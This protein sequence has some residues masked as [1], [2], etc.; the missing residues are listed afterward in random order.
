MLV[1]LPRD[2]YRLFQVLRLH[3]VLDNS[4]G[5]QLD[6]CVVVAFCDVNVP[7]LMLVCI[8]E[9]LEAVFAAS[10][11]Y[12]L[13]QK[14]WKAALHSQ[15]VT[16][17]L[18]KLANF[19]EVFVRENATAQ[20]GF[21]QSEAT[22]AQLAEAAIADDHESVRETAV[23]AI[24]QSARLD[25]VQKIIERLDGG[26]AHA[27]AALVTLRDQLPEVDAMIPAD[28][29][30]E[31]R[32]N[33]RR[34]RWQRHRRSILLAAGRGAL[35]GAIAMGFGFWLFLNLDGLN[36]EADIFDLFSLFVSSILV[37][38]L[39]GA[40]MLGAGAFVYQAVKSILDEGN[41]PAWIAASIVAGLLN[42]LLFMFVSFINPVGRIL[43][44]A[45]IS[46]FVMGSALCL[47]VLAPPLSNRYARFAATAAV[48]LAFYL[49]LRLLEMPFGINNVVLLLLAA[50]VTAAGFFF[51]FPRSEESITASTQ[52]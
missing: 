52:D 12:D 41:R 10:A 25:A 7:W 43:L 50:L 16:A 21:Y 47:V 32:R 31:I 29:R 4:K 6:L 44:P 35:G 33:V 28:I 39:L 15:Q 23:N 49:L 5:G 24:I 34:N 8:E 11:A 9:E 22:A 42:G 20:L 51:A 37:G 13:H 26:T 2:C 46:G 30:S 18:L 40:M 27:R 36:P 3:E 48:S 19:E 45:L 17:T 1:V 38:G 14:S